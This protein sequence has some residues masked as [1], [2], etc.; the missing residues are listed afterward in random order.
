MKPDHQTATRPADPDAD[1]LLR[2]ASG[3][4]Q[5]FD[6]LVIRNRQGVLNLIYRYVADPVEAEDLA[7]E[8]FVRLY[9]ARRRYRP[10]AKFSTFLHR[11]VVN[12]CLNEARRRRRCPT[13]TLVDMEQAPT[14]AAGGPE[15]SM[16]QAELSRQ[17]A[18]ALQ[19]LPETQR[20]A[21]ILSRFEGLSY[22]EIAA[23]MDL[24]VKAIEAL[25]YRAKQGLVR[26]L[27]DYVTS[28]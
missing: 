11:L 28:A 5:A 6:E 24:S 16:Q 22:A 17:V 9:Q 12:L 13:E 23:T 20:M 19:H 14:P 10:T 4:R 21:V 8:T 2:S 27:G 3:D 26:E 18:A 25:L 7:Q 15:H 1:L